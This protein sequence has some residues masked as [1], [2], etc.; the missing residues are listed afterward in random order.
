MDK[1]MMAFNDFEWTFSDH[2]ARCRWPWTCCILYFCILYNDMW[3]LLQDRFH[4][5]SL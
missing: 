3:T 5:M 4:R 1:L 2:I